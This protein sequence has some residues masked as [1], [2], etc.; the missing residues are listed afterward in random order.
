MSSQKLL[1]MVVGVIAGVLLVVGIVMPIITEASFNTE[2]INHE[3]TLNENPIGDLRLSYST[4]GNL[5]KY[6]T[7]D[8]SGSSITVSKGVIVEGVMQTADYTFTPAADMI[9]FATD[10]VAVTVVGSAVNLT[11]DG[12]VHAISESLTIKVMDKLY[13][14]EGSTDSE[15]AYTFV[16]YPD[17]DGTYANYTSYSH[18]NGTM[19]AIGSFAGV[20]WSSQGDTMVGGNPYGFSATVTENDGD[21]TGVHYG[22]TA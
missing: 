13:V 4:E 10:D 16:Y 15:Y 19:Y 8:I 14:S 2:I 20:S 17:A 12:Y 3:S 22:V 5:N 21:T 7:F 6:V 18:D 9:L 1:A 11:V